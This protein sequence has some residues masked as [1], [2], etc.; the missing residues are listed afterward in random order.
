MVTYFKGKYVDLI[1]GQSVTHSKLI[2][3]I[4]YA[5]TLKGGN[6]IIGLVQIPIAINYI[7]NYQ[8]GVWITISTLLNWLS[9]FDIGLG[10]GLKNRLTESITNNDLVKAKN[11]VSTT[12]AILF[13]ISITLLSLYLI[14]YNLIDWNELLNIS[15]KSINN[16]N[17]IFLIVI[18][19]FSLQFVLQTLNNVLIAIHES[20]K[21]SVISFIGQLSV[22]LGV[23]IMKSLIPG[24]L[25][26]LVYVLVICPNS[27]LLIASF[28]QY[29]KK[30]N[31]ISP[32]VKNVKFYLIK[33]IIGL[34][35]KFF[36]L[37]IGSIALFQ[38]NNVIIAKMFG[39]TN[40]TQYNIGYKYFSLVTMLFNIIMAPYW[41]AFTEA[42]TR[43]DYK[44]MNKSV[45]VLRLIWLLSIVANIILTIFS[46]YLIR[47]WVGDRIKINAGIIV[48]LSIFT[49][50]NNWM[51]IHTYFLNGIAKIKLQLYLVITCAIIN[52]PLSIY[53]GD[54]WGIEGIIINNSI[55]FLIMGLCFSIQT[56]KILKKES[57]GI[58]N[59]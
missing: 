34:S 57:Y 23:I 46:E 21:V 33:D 43:K 16:L 25:K 18:I 3:N 32:N 15:H 35:G 19:A 39:P 37:Q 10:N 49:I 58:W 6:I 5:I 53:S 28:Y 42:Y 54:R 50:I 13:F 9:F 27:V 51:I 1:K 14:F 11:Y 40:V 17:E 31:Y 29:K 55:L 44:W 47:I 7:N 38:I 30:I 22:L 20:A 36:I 45:K 26:N 56:D 2:S 59:K 41:T 12:Y 48:A 8:Y 52:I 4:L 24:N